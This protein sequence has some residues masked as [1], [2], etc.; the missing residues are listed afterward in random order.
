MDYGATMS[1]CATQ[2][3]GQTFTNVACVQ[4]DTLIALTIVLIIVLVAG[5]AWLGL[6]LNKFMDSVTEYLD[7]KSTSTNV[8]AFYHLTLCVYL[9]GISLFIRPHHWQ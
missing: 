4:L 3:L 9:K 2:V 7:K 6:R 8:T 5:L 1:D